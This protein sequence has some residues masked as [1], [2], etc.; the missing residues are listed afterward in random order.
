MARVSDRASVTG[1]FSNCSR[2]AGNDSIESRENC[3][4]LLLSC[5]WTTI[6][7][8]LPRMLAMVPEGKMQIRI[9]ECN[10]LRVIHSITISGINDNFSAHMIYSI[11]IEY[12]TKITPQ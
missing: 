11:T 7:A 6:V 5:I 4:I 9:E 8:D 12:E 2:G 1:S 10:F 3:S